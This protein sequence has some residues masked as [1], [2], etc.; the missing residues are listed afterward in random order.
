VGKLRPMVIAQADPITE[1]GLGTV[2]VVP[3]TTQ[4]RQAPGHC[5]SRS[6]AATAFS[7]TPSRWRISPNGTR[8]DFGSSSGRS[9]YAPACANGRSGLHAFLDVAPETIGC[10]GSGKTRPTGQLDIAVMQPLVRKG[11]VN[12]VVQSYGQ[13]IVDECHHIAAALTDRVAK[14]Y[15]L[16]GRLS[17]RQRSATV[18]ALEALPPDAPRVVLATGRL[19]VEGR[20]RPSTAQHPVAGHAHVM[21]GHSAAVRR[22]PAPAA[23]RPQP[24]CT[25][26]SP[27][28]SYR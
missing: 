24:W 22:P 19:V 23:Q 4:D 25:T 13:V 2:I 3:L 12:P 28:L 27:M 9:G 26:A 7:A 6:T 11:E 21:E 5:G 15:L 16:H 8:A 17:A 10:I 20:V 1:A 18:A 14:L